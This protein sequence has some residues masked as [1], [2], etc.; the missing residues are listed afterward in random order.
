[1]NLKIEKKIQTLLK[2]GGSAGFQIDGHDVTEYI[3]NQK[4][5]H[6]QEKDQYRKDKVSNLHFNSNFFT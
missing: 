3:L 2:E 6:Q 4:E 5:R 1:M